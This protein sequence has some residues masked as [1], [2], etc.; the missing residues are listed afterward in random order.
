MDDYLTKPVDLAL[1]K[2]TIQ[3]PRKRYWCMNV[4]L[5]D[6]GTRRRYVALRAQVVDSKTLSSKHRVYKN[7]FSF[8]YIRLGSFSPLK[9]P[10][11]CVFVRARASEWRVRIKNTFPTDRVYYKI[12]RLFSR[13]YNRLGP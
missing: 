3:R 11:V 7:F 4:L 12:C 2:Q 8:V 13:R 6:R 1:L 10:S 9:R 5:A